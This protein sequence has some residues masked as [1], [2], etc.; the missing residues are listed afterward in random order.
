M[1]PLEVIIRAEIAAHGPMPF[2]QFMEICMRHPQHGYYMAHDPFG[3]D[4][5]FT[6][7]PEISQMFGEMVALWCYDLWEKMGRPTRYTLVECG[8]GR[9]TL[10]DDVLRTLKVSPACLNAAEIVLIEKSPF[11]KEKQAEKLKAYSVQWVEDAA[12]LPALPLI[13]FSNEMFDTFAIRRFQKTKKGWAEQAVTVK[14]NRLAFT[15]LAINKNDQV[16]FDD[17]VY[18]DAAEESYA[19][20]SPDCQKWMDAFS[21]LLAA[22]S[23]GALMIDYGYD[24]PRAVDTVQAIAKQHFA[25]I[26]E[27][28][29]CAD[30][31]AYVDFG[32][33]ARIAVQHGLKVW[34]LTPQ[35]D[36]L[37]RCGIE[38]RAMLLKQRANDE[39]KNQIDAAL[40]RLIKP[41]QMGMIFKAFCVTTPSLPAPLGF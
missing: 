21:P 27:K 31:T 13:L 17:N 32:A 36:F 35:R 12:S 14:D 25:P 9:G 10:M 4:G 41:E 33:F 2:T 8:P 37:M 5:D 40:A 3:Q 20:F 19:E 23:G 6:T 26:L 30:I 18:H 15:L 11:L 1:T 28:A 24:G 22:H 38:Q 29:G 34:P 39:Q 7:A 16:L